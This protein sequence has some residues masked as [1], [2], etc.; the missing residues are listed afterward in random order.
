MIIPGWE[1]VQNF[2][3][4][5]VGIR[6]DSASATGSAMARIKHIIDAKFP[7]TDTL[8][9][10]RQ[11]PRGALA[12]GTSAAGTGT[13]YATAYSF[14]GKGEALSI[15]MNKAS[16]ASA[17]TLRLTIDGVYQVEYSI[18]ALTTYTYMAN[19]FGETTATVGDSISIG[20]PFKTSVLIE[21][22]TAGGGN[23]QCQ[24]VVATE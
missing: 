9:G 20:I 17:G 13:S 2:V 3:R 12:I 23:A 21:L 22:K 6:S 14:S 4:R 8:V 18:A 19:L 16:T 5:Q 11:K 7:A 24:W 1:I 10:Q 15:R